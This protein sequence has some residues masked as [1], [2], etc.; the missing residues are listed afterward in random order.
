MED[1]DIW[2]ESLCQTTALPDW[3]WNCSQPHNNVWRFFRTIVSH[4]SVSVMLF[5][6]MS[7]LT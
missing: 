4:R 7:Y 3:S 1:N 6:V 5:L 2:L